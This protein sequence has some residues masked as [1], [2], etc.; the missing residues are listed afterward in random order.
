MI[1]KRRRDP[2][3]VFFGPLCNYLNKYEW[4]NQILIQT[5]LE[6]G[7]NMFNHHL[8]HMLKYSLLFVRNITIQ[9]VATPIH[10][11]LYFKYASLHDD[12]DIL[13]LDNQGIDL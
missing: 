12:F 8:S 2:V 1:Y 6:N 5:I 7:I 13:H 9:R 4:N 3:K 10:I 11:L